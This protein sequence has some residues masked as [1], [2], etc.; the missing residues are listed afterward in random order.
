MYFYSDNGEQRYHDLWIGTPQHG[1]N[2]KDPAMLVEFNKNS[3]GNSVVHIKWRGYPMG[4][5]GE[6]YAVSGLYRSSAV[7]D[8]DH[9]TTWYTRV[10]TSPGVVKLMYLQRQASSSKRN[11]NRL[12]L[13]YNYSAA[14]PVGN[15]N[16][17][18]R[19]CYVQISYFVKKD[20]TTELESFDT[21][22]ID[23]D[24]ADSMRS[25]FHAVLPDYD[26]SHS[27]SVDAQWAQWVSSTLD[28]LWSTYKDVEP[29][30]G[31]GRLRNVRRFQTTFSIPS[32]LEGK[33]LLDEYNLLTSGLSMKP[34]AAYHLGAMRQA[35]YLD[36]LDHV[37]I[38]NE[39]NIS[40]IVSLVSFIKG[41]VIDHRVEIP[42]S[43]NS[44]W[45]AYR[46]TYST[47]KS[48]MQEA[49]NFMHRTVG[50]DLFGRGFDCYGVTKYQFGNTIVTARCHLSM[51]PK[52]LELLDKIWTSLY[53]YGLSPS[54]Y[55][56]WDAIP[57]S[58]IVDWFI[59]IGDILSGYDKT[60][61]YDRTYNISDIWYSIKYSYTDETG[62]YTSY[63][64]WSGD[65]PPEFRGYYALANK[66]T[67]SDKVIGFRI[68]DLLSLS[69]K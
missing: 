14:R 13:T 7:L 21:I 27:K 38:M 12:I 51:V 29:L 20:G 6:R 55:V 64:R 30:G 8:K 26:S 16:A 59:P 46:Y 31:F 28:R 68:L 36:A 32:S 42:K 18:G 24:V 11:A 35:A 54:F 63:A 44:A 37:P 41:I 57:Y 56:V 67:T 5:N 62:T 49:I 48:D 3:T 10:D 34:Y 9:V 52:E 65:S 39:N 2:V 22:N 4:P 53:K 17:E 69:Y 60:R 45:L 58:F 40:N 66:G 47:T 50:K 19:Y 25:F 15:S 61:M 1:H 33:L 23:N 43:L